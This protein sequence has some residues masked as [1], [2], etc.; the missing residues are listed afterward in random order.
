MKISHKFFTLLQV[1]FWKNWHVD[2]YDWKYLLKHQLCS[3]TEEW[4]GK[5]LIHTQK[6]RLFKSDS[7]I[8][9]GRTSRCKPSTFPPSSWALRLLFFL[10]SDAASQPRIKY[11]SAEKSNKDFIDGGLPI[12]HL[13]LGRPTYLLLVDCIHTRCVYLCFKAERWYTK[14]QSRFYVR[15]KLPLTLTNENTLQVFWWVGVGKI[16][17]TK[18]D[19]LRYIM[20]GFLNLCSSPILLGR[21]NE[22]GWNGR[23]HYWA[24]ERRDS[25]KTCNFSRKTGMKEKILYDLGVDGKI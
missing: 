15:V 14:L 6:K 7:F 2:I 3:L 4:E 10:L 24:W 8:A 5:K 25:T 19:E 13:F 23:E 11:T 16:F 18:K 17:W 1:Q 12:P 21:S 20:R 22:R 9:I